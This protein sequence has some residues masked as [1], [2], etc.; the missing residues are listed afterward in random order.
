M[1]KYVI[2][3]SKFIKASISEIEI[4]SETKK[5]VNLKCGRR[6]AKLSEF[7]CYFDTREEAKQHLVKIARN[8]ADYTK[9]RLDD[10][11]STLQEIIKL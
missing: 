7:K 9:A 6:E 11:V 4:E 8:N 1:I 2:G 5:F 10:A 3:G